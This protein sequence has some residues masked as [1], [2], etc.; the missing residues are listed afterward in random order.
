MNETWNWDD[1][2]HFLAIARA[3]GLAGATSVTGVS[4][5]TLSRRMTSLERALGLSLFVRRQN[6][7]GLT[8]AGEQ[9]LVRAETLE[10]GALGIERW[11]SESDPHPVV[12]LA[13]GAWTSRFVARHADRLLEATETV[14]M[15]ILTGAPAFDLVRREANL[16]L[17]NRRPETRGLAG[18]RLARVEF[19]V[20]G[21]ADYV[22]LGPGIPAISDRWDDGRMRQFDG[23]N[24]VMFAP[25]G[26]KVPSVVWLEQRLPREARFKCT[27][28]Q[29]ALEATLSG[30]GLCILPCFIGDGQ[31]G[32]VR[33]SALLLPLAHDQWLV[34]HDDDRH[35]PHIRRV[36]G[37]LAKLIRAHR[38]LFSGQSVAA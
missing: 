38:K 21:Q 25:P 3:G 26:P 16:G 19:A 13:A 15:E 18:Q 36:A 11:R 27:S 5:P 2:R 14:T 7:Y 9:F 24:W 23:C 12:R 22:R 37:R 6:G 1:V 28:A 29:A 10:K 4:A 35:S 34:S 33:A 32:L 17:R 8:E 20:Y 30:I 31:A